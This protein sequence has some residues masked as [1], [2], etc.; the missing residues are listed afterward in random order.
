MKSSDVAASQMTTLWTLMRIGGQ[1]Y[2]LPSKDI[3]QVIPAPLRFPLPYAPAHIVGMAHF[4]GDILPCVAIDAVLSDADQQAD[5]KQCA[6]I[7]HGGR[8][9]LIMAQTVLRQLDLSAADIHVIEQDREAEHDSA[10]VGEVSINGQS[11]FLLDGSYL[12][13]FSASREQQAGR[14]G[15]IDNVDDFTN[16]ESSEQQLFLHVSICGQAY[17]IDVGLI[18]EIVDI[19]QVALIPGAPEPI[20]GLAGIRGQSH[21]LLSSQRWLGLDGDGVPQV[22]VAVETAAGLVLL[23]AGQ[24]EAVSGASAS[25]I[26]PLDDDA[27]RVCG[28]IQQPGQ[29]LRGILNIAALPRQVPDLPR[30][31]PRVEGHQV[32]AATEATSSFLLVRWDEELFALP[33]ADV[34]RLEQSGHV[35]RLDHDVFE[36]VLNFDG[37]SIPVIRDAVF[38]GMEANNSH[39]DGYLILQADDHPYAAPLQ[40]AD[41]IIEVTTR[42]VMRTAVQRDG[43]FLGTLRHG[44]ALVSL[45][46]P[47]FF[48]QQAE[49]SRGAAL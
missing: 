42:Q 30:Y 46:N 16:T 28:V 35:R 48:R 19:E 15:L 40:H 29:P 27:G 3:I 11:V 41:R 5:Y 20:R 12:V 49:D 37:D 10:I 26:K 43:R 38:Y 47:A 7:G 44:D 8:R 31:I 21:L 14:P 36:A 22:A 6:V 24:I 18:R 2:A 34:V 1:H 23:D 17:A 25:V 4:D 32:E 45:I 9:A 39:R 13:Q 33:L